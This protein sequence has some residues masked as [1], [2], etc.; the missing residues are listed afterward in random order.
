MEGSILRRHASS[1]SISP[2]CGERSAKFVTVLSLSFRPYRLA[3]PVEELVEG[4]PIDDDLPDELP[5]AEELP[6]EDELPALLTRS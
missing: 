5:A 3:L 2:G 1:P 6:V 4:L